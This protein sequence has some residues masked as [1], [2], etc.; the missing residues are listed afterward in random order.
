MP[1]VQTS[2]ARPAASPAS[3][4]GPV[5]VAFGLVYFFWGSTYTAIRIAGQTLAPLL[6]GASRCLLATVILV[7]ICFVRRS[8]LRLPLGVVWRLALVGVLL[9]SVNNV[10]LTWAETMVPSGLAALI[11][12]TTPIMVAVIERLLPGGEAMN[13]RGWAGTLLGTAGILVLVWP[14]LGRH[15]PTG[16][17]HLLAYGVLLVA[18]L[19]FAVGSILSRRFAFQ[20]D[21]FV[22]TAYQIGAASL[23]NLLIAVLSGNLRTATWTRSGLLAIAYLS[24]F[25]TVVGLSCFTYL[26][27]HV[28]VTKVATYAFVNPVVAVLLGIFVLGEHLER[29]ELLGTAIIVAAVAMVIF[30]RIKR[31]GEDATLQQ[32]T[33][34]RP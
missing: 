4:T 8:S 24:V 7:A 14:A 28:P 13:R 23:V 26:L 6:V 31:G 10:L 9:M 17:R 16:G 29:T 3:L 34:N 18:A 30:S 21:T 12:A 22:A 15:A 1:S 25:G 33:Q 19:A 20:A 32:P 2:P 11:I 27:K 5:L